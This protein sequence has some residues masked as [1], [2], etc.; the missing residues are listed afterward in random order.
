MNWGTNRQPESVYL[1][2]IQK[3]GGFSGES[4]YFFVQK[5]EMEIN[6]SYVLR[7]EGKAA[8]MQSER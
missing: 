8:I 2:N 7:W 5:I 4:S 3:S 6:T 1:Q